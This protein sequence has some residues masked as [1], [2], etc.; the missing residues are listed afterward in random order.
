VLDIVANHGSPG[1]T[2]PVD[3][4]GFGQVY[5][6]DGTADRRPRQP[7]A[8]AA[9]PGQQPAA[10]LLQHQARP[11]PAV[12]LRRDNPAVMDHLVGAYL[13]WIDQGA[14][15]FRVDTMRHVPPEF[16]RLRRAHPRQASGLLHVRRGLR[17][18]GGEDRR[19]HAPRERRH[20]RARLPAQ[21]GDAEVFEARAA[22]FAALAPA[23][24]LKDGPYANPYEL[25]TF[26][27]NHDMARMNASDAG[28]IDAH[29]WLFTARG[30]PVIYYGSEIGFMRGARRAQR[31]PQ[32]L[33]RRGHR[34]RARPPDPPGP[35]PRRPAA[36]SLAGAAAR[37]AVQPQARRRRGRVLSRAADRRHEPDRAGAAQQAA[38]PAPFAA[39]TALGDR[40]WSPDTRP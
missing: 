7:A 1:W 35:D 8:G 13:Q 2:M 14:D 29:H 3:Q 6:A 17:L 18:R 23:L 27:D 31:Q 32:L 5:D 36:R 39:S 24:F 4:P 20:E 11:G 16:W 19:A 40:A 38:A 22:D 10:R 37:P 26:Y 34:S 30:I 33:R 15:A 21:A 9:R 25:M 28:F 12:R